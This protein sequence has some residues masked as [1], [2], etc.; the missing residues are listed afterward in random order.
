LVVDLFVFILL[1]DRP[2]R[3]FLFFGR[4]ETAAAHEAFFALVSVR[5][6]S[7]IP[8]FFLSIALSLILFRDLSP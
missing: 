4:D 5:P 1:L 6:S 3:R 8:P 7:S 2:A